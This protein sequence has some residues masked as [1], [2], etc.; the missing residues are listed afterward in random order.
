LILYL[1]AKIVQVESSHESLLSKI[2]ETHPIF[3]FRAK[4]KIIR[5]IANA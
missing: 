3:A 4:I 1:T 2:A 5:N